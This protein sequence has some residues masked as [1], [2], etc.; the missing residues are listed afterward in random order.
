MAEAELVSLLELLQ[1]RTSPPIA[2]EIFHTRGSVREG[3]QICPSCRVRTI[4]QSHQ[5]R[6]L[7]HLP[8][9]KDGS[10]H[11]DL[12]VLRYAKSKGLS[13]CISLERSC[14]LHHIPLISPPPTYTDQE[15]MTAEYNTSI[16]PGQDL[17][18]FNPPS[19]NFDGATRLRRERWWK[20]VHDRLFDD[21]QASLAHTRNRKD[22]VQDVAQ[23]ESIT[24]LW[25]SIQ[26][27]PTYHLG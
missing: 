21:V 18:H 10:G 14:P 8:N 13:L 12:T 19:L 16:V 9:Q 11:P 22:A 7:K 27:D 6:D 23:E 5:L 2:N 3:T 4:R 26:K 1:Q 24:A 15:Q 25:D 17:S 20:Q